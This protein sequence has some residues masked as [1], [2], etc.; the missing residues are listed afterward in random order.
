MIFAG[1]FAPLMLADASAGGVTQPDPRAGLLQMGGFIL[2]MFIFMYVL[3]IRP[4]Q[5]K[6]REHADLLKTLK[7]GDKVVTSSGILGTVV[8]VKDRSV[9]VRSG[10][11][12]LELLKSAVS[13]ILER[14]GSGA[15]A[16]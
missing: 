15:A 6:A 14:S 16:S 7:S 3:S 12:K 11:T 4:Q 1:I 13:E 10:D 2:V 8:S 5:K 9:T